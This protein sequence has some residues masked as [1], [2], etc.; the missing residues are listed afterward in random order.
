[1][2]PRGKYTIDLYKKFL[3]MHGMTFNHRIE[4]KNI[5]R[6]FLLP[7]SDEVHTTFVVGLA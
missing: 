2:V 4:Y 5:V 6:A 7:L 1:V 3:R